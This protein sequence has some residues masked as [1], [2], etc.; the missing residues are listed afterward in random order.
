MTSTSAFIIGISGRSGSGKSTF[1]RKIHEK[2][3]ESTTLHTMDNYYRPISE[4]IIDDNGYINFD[5]P[6]S[7]YIEKFTHD[8]ISLKNGKDIEIKEYDYKK[9][10]QASNL[11][12]PTRKIILVEGLFIF[13]IEAVKNMLDFSIMM[14]TTRE[15]C[16]DRRLNRDQN[17]RGYRIPEI[18]YRYFNHAE[19]AFQ[20]IILPHWDDCDL[21][22]D[23]NENIMEGIQMLSSIIQERIALQ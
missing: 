13:Q 19:P 17:E 21:I 5:L 23:N 12:I 14:T 16:Y 18:E 6:A 15:L 7:F 2:F 20:Q 8:L 22:V 11:V 1:V 4:Q 3:P 10:G 9:S